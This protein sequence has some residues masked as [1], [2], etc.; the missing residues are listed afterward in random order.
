MENKTET[1]TLYQILA[2]NGLKYQTKNHSKE[3]LNKN[4]KVGFYLLVGYN[5]NV[6]VWL[7]LNTKNL[8]Y[9]RLL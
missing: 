1:K 7:N 5:V 4:F 9:K 2:E 8:I 6:E 3:M